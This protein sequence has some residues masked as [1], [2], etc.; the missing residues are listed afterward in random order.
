MS[1]KNIWLSGVEKIPSP[2]FNMRSCVEGELQ[3]YV[4]L[5]VIHN[6]SLPPAQCESDFNQEHV[7]AFFC[8]KLDLSA[9]EIFSQLESIKV[10][11]H[12]YIRRDGTIVQFVPLEMAAW[13]AGVSNF[14][15]REA[16]NDFSIGIELQ[17]TDVMQYT[18]KQYNSLVRATKQIQQIFCNITVDNIVGHVHIAPDRKTDPGASFNWQKYKRSLVASAN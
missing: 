13:H 17:G 2:N 7:E 3:S 8:N 9:D 16:C 18:E 6:I 4:D 5:L 1:G 12:L 15:G 10:S 11:S 14:K